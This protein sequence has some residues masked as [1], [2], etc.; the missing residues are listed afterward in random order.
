MTGG[1]LLAGSVVLA[2]FAAARLAAALLP[3]A[4]W[5][6]RLLAW[7][8]LLLLVAHGLMLAL[9]ALGMAR[10]P[11]VV[12][13]LA[14]IA[15][16]A[17]RI[18]RASPVRLRDDLAAALRHGAA[19][20]RDPWT[21]FGLAAAA[22]ALAFNAIRFGM[23]GV[24]F[25]S[26]DLAYHAPTVTD[27]LQ[28]GSLDNDRVVFASYYA[29]NPHLVVLGLAA[30]AG[31]FR[32]AW[33]AN[34]LWMALATAALLAFGAQHGRRAM[35]I[36]GLGAAALMASPMTQYFGRLLGP[37]DLA[38]ASALMAG[39]VLAR[40][41]RGSSPGEAI[42]LAALG[43][44]MVGYAAGTKFHF[45]PAIFLLAPFVLLSLWRARASRR[46]PALWLRTAVW[47]FAGAFATGSFWYLHNMRL[48]GNP[49]F[50]TA[51]G[52]FDGP[53]DQ[54]YFRR[55]TV[56]HFVQQ[57]RGD[58]DFWQD[59]AWQALDWP[60][61]MGLLIAASLL[62]GFGVLGVAVRRCIAGRTL[63]PLGSRPLAAWVLSAFLLVL[64]RKLPYGATWIG[65]SDLHLAIRY[66]LPVAPMATMMAAAF[67]AGKG[68]WRAWLPGSAF[69]GAIAW[70]MW[71]VQGRV[72]W[73]SSIAAGTT[74]MVA[75][76]G[77]WIL[78]AG[79][80]MAKSRL[81][82]A[83]AGVVLAG[84][85]AARGAL[86]VQ[87]HTFLYAGQAP[88]QAF[89][90]IMPVIDAL[91]PGS[92]IG[93]HTYSQWEVHHLYG[94]RLQHRPVFLDQF[95]RAMPDLHEAWLAGLTGPG[96]QS[97]IGVTPQ[98]VLAEPEEYPRRLLESGVEVVVLSR[99]MRNEDFPPHRDLIAAMPEFEVIH[100]DGFNEIHRRITPP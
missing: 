50:P 73:P 99:F 30:H 49:V 6:R 16:C 67:A 10:L 90:A 55:T 79:A 36:A 5:L 72:F 43:G 20:C 22:A 48:T 52:P 7:A 32:W 81:A 37:T 97:R 100:D 86:V 3:E 70:S 15:G 8:C 64:L 17:W 26:D 65:S 41:R 38:A 18:G 61:P 87:P 94:T 69:M 51:V 74:A 59:F 56:K 9:G 57:R 25:G 23:L 91:P 75:L 47:Y 28:R 83:A 68:A 77:R 14:A 42:V 66:V 82:P 88:F 13:G 93:Q 12:M 54:G 39:L 31:D 45:A 2:A 19:A 84:I 76:G 58:L 89:R 92:R 21:R 98:G 60:W 11:F 33:L 96:G 78:A 53:V 4:G 95:G 46:R 71:E 85:L 1:L 24:M 34:L 63:L 29:F 40:S 27:W 80:R 44:A 35:G 62:A